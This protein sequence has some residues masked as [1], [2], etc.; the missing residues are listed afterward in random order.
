[1]KRRIFALTLALSMVLLA[2]CGPKGEDNSSGNQSSSTSSNSDVSTMA[3][4]GSTSSPDSSAPD[5]SQP[6]GSQPDGS[7]STS[8][9]SS[10]PPVDEPQAQAS[11]SLNRS[12]FTLFKAGATFQMKAKADPAG[13]TLTWKSSDESVATVSD[14]GLVTAMAVGNATI[15]ATDSE[16]G[17]TASCIVRCNW[18]EQKPEE[19]GPADGSDSSSSSSSGDT[20]T[21]AG[22]VDLSA[23]ASEVME[24]Y[25]FG[26]LS[27]A[28]EATLDG[29]YP[30][31]KDISTDQMLVYVV[32]MTMNNGEFGLVQ[33][34]DS[35]DVD[36]VKSIFQARIDRMTGA[37]GQG[38]PGAW[39]PGP[40]EQW[41]NNSRVVSNGNYVMMVVHEN[42]DAIVDAFNALF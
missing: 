11:L 26:F 5:A 22:N 1:M 7:G 37:D 39:Y 41:K 8:S 3:P 33:V 12:D 21:P 38:N 16:T 31:L 24:S 29:L 25:E 13:G 18:E 10:Q 2:A 40:T 14:K 28:D 17:L 35:K 15:T 6:D 23:F 4:D 36:T 9:D 19:S 27:L 42:C 20:S 30:G 34:K 32:Q